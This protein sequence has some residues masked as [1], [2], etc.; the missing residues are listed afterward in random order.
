MKTDNETNRP[1]KNQLDYTCGLSDEE[2]TRRFKEAIRIDEEIRSI[3]GLPQARYDDITKRAYLLYP[4]GRRQ[5]IKDNTN[6]GL[7]C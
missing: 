5:Y 6:K 3:L 4:D 7:P 2:I 1:E